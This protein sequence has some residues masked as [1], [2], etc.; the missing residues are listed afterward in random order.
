V[1]LSIAL[2]EK[3]VVSRRRNAVTFSKQIESNLRN[4]ES[5]HFIGSLT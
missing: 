5:T 4:V 3:D 2:A 1:L